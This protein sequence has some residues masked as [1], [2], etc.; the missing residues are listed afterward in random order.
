M[1]FHFYLVASPWLSLAEWVTDQSGNQYHPLSIQGYLLLLAS[2][3]GVS[4]VRIS[5]HQGHTG[6]LTGTWEHGCCCCS[7]S[8]GSTQKNKKNKKKRI[9]EPRMGFSSSY[10]IQSS[11]SC[12]CPYLIWCLNYRESDPADQ[13]QRPDSVP[14]AI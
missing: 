9:L 6:N 10:Q 1:A 14:F 11:Y 12:S 7:N 5:C 13:T 4:Q 2:Q 3:A 8:S